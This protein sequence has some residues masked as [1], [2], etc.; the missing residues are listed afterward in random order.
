[1]S[2]RVAVM[3]AGGKGTRL[4]PYTTAV[5]K[6]LVVIGEYPI[7]EILIRQLKNDGFTDIYLAVNHQAELIRDYFGDGRKYGIKIRYFFEKTPLGTM[8]PL[9]AMREDLPDRFLVMNGDVLTD[10]SFSKFLTQH[11]ANQALLTI[12][13][14]QRDEIIDYGVLHVDK[15]SRLIG[16]E[17]KPVLS[18]TVSMGVYGLC[19]KTIDY[20][21][22][23]VYFGFDRLVKLLIDH[24]EPVEVIIYDG[25]WNDIGRP[26]DY[27]QAIQD[28]KSIKG[29]LLL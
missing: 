17:E 1:M 6:P 23:D 26:A 25:Y 21:P 16:F 12:S 19:K 7:A 14:K 20:I 13:G 22:K 3:L 5:P 18:H 2:D 15:S 4:L 10:L 11:N 28:F 8:G 24:Q 29:R 9:S 27:K